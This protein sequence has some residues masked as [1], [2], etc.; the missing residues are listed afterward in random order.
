LGAIQSRRVEALRGFVVIQKNSGELVDIRQLILG[1]ALGAA[2]G[3]SAVSSAQDNTHDG[4][5]LLHHLEQPGSYN[6]AFA[7]GYV[8]GVENYLHADKLICTPE[9]VRFGQMRDVVIKYLRDNPAQ[10]HQSRF[11]LVLDALQAAFPC[12]ENLS[13]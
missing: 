13:Q 1:T 9:G 11:V 8:I 6:E 3:L 12:K 2:L 10:R 4:N 7:F 5:E